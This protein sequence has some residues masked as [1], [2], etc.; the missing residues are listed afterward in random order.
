MFKKIKAIHL[1]KSTIFD[2]VRFLL[3][4]ILIFTFITSAQGQQKE[5]IAKRINSDVII[6]GKLNESF[7]EEIQPAE[8]FQMIEPINGKMERLNQ[9]TKV[10]FAYDDFSIYIGAILHDKN[11]GYDDPNMAGIM[12]E[13]GARDEQN[14]STDIFGLFINPFNDGINEFSFS[15][16][17]SGCFF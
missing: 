6:D 11:A 9:K 15:L 16:T 10:K 3:L 1:L 2:F 8:N 5:V 13:L 7:W 4:Y 14:K 12:K 17:I